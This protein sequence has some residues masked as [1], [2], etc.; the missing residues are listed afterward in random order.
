MPMMATPVPIKSER[1]KEL[2]TVLRALSV[3]F[4][5]RAWA[6]TILAPTE[7]PKKEPIKR[8]T[9][10]FEALTAAKEVSPSPKFET[11]NWS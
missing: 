8:L 6:K 2:W 10:E 5:P 7:M 11:I 9:M 4:F 3:S 1:S